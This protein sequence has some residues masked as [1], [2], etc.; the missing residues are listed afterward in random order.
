MSLRRKQTDLSHHHLIGPA[1]MW[2]ALS[3]LGTQGWRGGLTT[4]P[5]GAPQLEISLAD[6]PEI[7]AQVGDWLIDDMGWRKLT[8]DQVA[9]NY[10]VTES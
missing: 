6:N 1:E 9:A 7:T 3:D 5:T 2:A 4:G 8:A 10:D